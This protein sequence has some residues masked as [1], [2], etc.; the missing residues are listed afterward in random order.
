MSNK[1]LLKQKKHILK[2]I[3]VNID[4]NNKDRTIFIFLRCHENVPSCSTLEMPHW[5]LPAG[6]PGSIA[7]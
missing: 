4:S 1:S 2:E 7:N 5:P 6:T 3:D